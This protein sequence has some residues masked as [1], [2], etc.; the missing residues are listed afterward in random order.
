MSSQLG[1]EVQILLAWWQIDILEKWDFPWIKPYFRAIYSL[2]FRQTG[3]FNSVLC[4]HYKIITSQKFRRVFWECLLFVLD[5]VNISFNSWSFHYA[6]N[7][8]L[9]L[10][11]LWH[12]SAEQRVD[13][14][15]LV[16]LQP[17]PS[18]GKT[19]SW[20]NLWVSL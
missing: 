17:E 10:L 20:A 19:G 16:L 1:S 9:Y 13:C 12:R 14:D 11:F 2:I 15:S 6:L 3:R 18:S 4:S 7:C 5:A 8:F